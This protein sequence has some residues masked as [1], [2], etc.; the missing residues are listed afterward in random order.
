MDRL[1]PAPAGVLALGQGRQA[2]HNA[3]AT[4]PRP[5]N[6]MHQPIQTRSQADGR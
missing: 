3:K 1:D 4:P 6:Q 5:Q 2:L